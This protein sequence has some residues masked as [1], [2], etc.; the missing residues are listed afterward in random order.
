MRI[1]SIVLAAVV[2]VPVLACRTEKPT[3]GTVA[4]ATAITISPP[5]G[6]ST[7][8]ALAS[9]MASSILGSLGDMS[10]SVKG[11]V[12]ATGGE[13]GALE[14]TF[15]DCQSGERNGFYG[16]DFYVAG[17]EE[18]RLRYVHDEAAGEVVK[19]GVPSKAGT[20]MVLDKAAK[21]TVLEGNVAKTN[22]KT[23]TPKGDIHHVEGHVKFE[24]TQ[25]GGKG[26][27]SGDLTFAH[28]H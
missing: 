11:N 5:T 19:I 2:V 18:L 1:A 3:T 21:C 15:S 27:V 17:S 16:A 23:W 20:F 9:A 4:S 24:C 26:Q 28:C 7:G 10:P 13:L 12:H 14:L 6:T 25:A 8:P 22:V